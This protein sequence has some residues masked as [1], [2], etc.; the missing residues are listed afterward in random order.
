MKVP[1]VVLPGLNL[2]AGTS[3][4]L[5]VLLLPLACVSLDK[6]AQ[7][8]KCAAENSCADDFVPRNDAAVAPPSDTRVADEP[9]L[10]GDAGP[11]TTFADTVLG[12][13]DVSGG[14]ADVWGPEAS[15]IEVLPPTDTRPL[16]D[17]PLDPPDTKSDPLD[18]SSGDDVEKQDVIKDAIED[19]PTDDASRE[20][21]IRA[22][23]PGPETPR[24]TGTADVPNTACPAVNPVTGGNLVLGTKGPVCFVTCDVIKYGWGCSSFDDSQRT[25]KVNGQ[26]VKCA[27]ALPAQKQPGSYFYFEVSAGGNTWDSIHWSG[28][29]VA[30]CPTPSGGFVP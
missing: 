3:L 24:D 14:K 11:D 26:T 20:A 6:P 5:V 19:G 22:D 7:V 25:I 1:E 28:D 15:A 23:V 29:M 27:G 9:T 30:T 17:K 18:V 21:G 13:T 8:A 12:K 16:A 10:K 2:R 4:L